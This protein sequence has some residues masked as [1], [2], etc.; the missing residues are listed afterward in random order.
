MR[1]DLKGKKGAL[2]AS[3]IEMAG[4]VTIMSPLWEE[5]TEA[6]SQTSGRP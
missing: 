6:L 4:L 3:R 2:L 1:R 5:P